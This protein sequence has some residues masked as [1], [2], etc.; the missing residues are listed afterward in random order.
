MRDFIDGL[1]SESLNWA[2]LI[3]EKSCNA[4][5]YEGSST[6]LSKRDCLDED[7]PDK[8]L[9]LAPRTEDSQV[10]HCC[11]VAPWTKYEK[12]QRD[13]EDC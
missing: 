7:L 13:K 2:R 8:S 3:D 12:S 11:V 1:D 4:L 6:D 10:H 9:W 5:I